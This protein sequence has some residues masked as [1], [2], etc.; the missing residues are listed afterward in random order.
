MRE[1]TEHDFN[2]TTNN[3]WLT[4]T[5]PI[6]EAFWHTKYFLTMMANTPS[7]STVRPVLAERL[8]SRALPVRAAGGSRRTF[9]S[10]QPRAHGLPRGAPDASAG[11]L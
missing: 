9:L 6:L 10:A 5:R 8:G 1:G 3:E 2:E 11:A 7:S 4:Q